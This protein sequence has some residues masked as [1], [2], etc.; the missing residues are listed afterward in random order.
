MA[1]IHVYIEFFL[2]LELLKLKFSVIFGQLKKPINVYVNLSFPFISA[3]RAICGF[4]DVPVLWEGS[5]RVKYCPL[6]K[7]RL[8]VLRN[9]YMT[10]DNIQIL[11]LKGQYIE[12]NKVQNACAR[13]ISKMV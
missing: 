1:L 8:L 10:T 12:T 7:F 4:I 11:I 6:Q 3:N 2:S 5:R 9:F 13:N